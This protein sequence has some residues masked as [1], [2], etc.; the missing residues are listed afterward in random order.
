VFLSHSSR[1]KP[2]VIQ[3][4]DALRRYGVSVWLDK[5]EIRPG[6]HFGEALEQALDNSRTVALIVSPEAVTSGWVKEE[7]YRALA[8]ATARGTAVQ[9]IPVILRKAELPGFLQSRNW[10]DFRDESS[11]AQ[12]VWQLAWGITGEKPAQ[13]LE[14][15]VTTPR[16]SG[17]H[18]KSP[19]AAD[20][21]G[22]P[23]QT[24]LIPAG[25]FLMGSD[26][27]GDW[28]QH[29][30]NLSPSY[31]I[32]QYPVTNEQY[33]K[34][35]E[36]NPDRRPRAGGWHF[37]TPPPGKHNHPVV[38]VSWDDARAY[39]AWLSREAGHSYRLPTEA[40]WEK[41]ARGDQDSRRY[42]WGDE[43]TPD[44]C[45]CNRAQTTPVDHYPAG[46]SPYKCYDMAGN[47]R[48]WTGTL[49]GKDWKKAQFIYPYQHDKRENLNAASNFY[50]IYRGGAY[51]DEVARL[52]CSPRGYRGPTARD[53][54][55]GFRVVLEIESQR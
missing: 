17:I 16:S 32:G 27:T 12:S 47:V 39:C 46:Q 13:V 24:V 38:G 7:Y 25:P 45:N 23:L 19:R 43:L 37:T 50:R 8:L 20:I 54:N 52:G 31:R 21:L 48:E 42:P 29:Q 36:Q 26:A 14:L 53:D 44:I 4:K 35:A 40:Q 34:F 3:L 6:D 10:V 33:V 18:G 28:Q 41:A 5:D 30:Y 11:Y 55:L 51:N 49:W 1:D 15:T 2:W 22:V 9:I